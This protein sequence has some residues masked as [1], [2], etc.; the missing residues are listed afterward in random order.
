[1]RP[2]LLASGDFMPWGGMDRANF[3]LASRLADI[4]GEVHL[5]THCADPTLLRGGVIVHTVPRPAGAHALGMPL[6][7]RAARRRAEALQPRQVRVVAN[8]GNCLWDGLNWVHYV[9]AAY[10]PRPD[11][12]FASR[13]LAKAQRRYV[14]NRERDAIRQA[15]AVICNSLRTQRDVVD[16]LG[17]PLERTRVIYYGVDAGQF[18]TANDAER[19]AARAELKVGDGRLTALL[20]GAL[21]DRRKGFDVLFEAWAGLCD[22]SGWDVELLV[23]GE[24]RERSAWQARAAARGL[25]GRIRF[26]GYRRDMPRLFAAAD[27]LVHP[28]R[29]EAY[30]LA[31]HEAICRGVPAIV[32]GH[33]GVAERYSRSLAP[34]VL[35]EVSVEAVSA[36]LVRWRADVGVFAAAAE[37]LGGQWRARTWDMMADDIARLGDAC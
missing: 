16:R 24:G 14:L 15:R 22:R 8:G 21:G 25:S 28:A 30:G 6:L 18:Q 19:Q 37:E 13:L 34:L 3:A 29:Y 7:N 32:A 2:W 17:V 1:M 23:V 31:V 5:V 11:A 20:V 4:G 10:D 9:H 35:A 33:A 12:A 36:A 26:L 27:V